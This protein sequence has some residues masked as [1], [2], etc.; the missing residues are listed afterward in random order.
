MGIGNVKAAVAWLR[1][2][3][4]RDAATDKGRREAEQFAS[5]NLLAA[6]DQTLIEACWSYV[7]REETRHGKAEA[8]EV[9]SA[10]LAGE[11]R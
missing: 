7:A 1:E 2:A 8:N 4:A 10:I 3:N 6:K 11:W 9:A 5:H